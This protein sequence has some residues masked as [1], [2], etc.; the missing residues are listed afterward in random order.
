M[1]A[2]HLLFLAAALLAQVYVCED[3]LVWGRGGQ[4]LA[5]RR[6]TSVH[7]ARRPRATAAAPPLVCSP[8]PVRLHIALRWLRG[9]A[10]RDGARREYWDCCWLGATPSTRLRTFR[11]TSGALRRP[12]APFSPCLPATTRNPRRASLWCV[13]A[14]QRASACRRRLLYGGRQGAAAPAAAP[15]TR[16]MRLWQP[17]PCC[18]LLRVNAAT[19]SAASR[20]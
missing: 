19:P 17:P 12:A 10:H 9:L 20:G 4:V 15:R 8:S 14:G 1:R 16:C 3:T 7:T 18:V 6:R 2:R 11:R 5:V 13:H